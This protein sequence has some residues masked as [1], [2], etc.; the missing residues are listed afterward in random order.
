MKE[1]LI[2]F[3]SATI[4]LILG[5]L[6]RH[7]LTKREKKHDDLQMVNEAV[8]PLLESVKMLTAQTADLIA[9]L[10]AE[11]TAHLE[12]IRKTEALL[13]EREVL[14]KKI[15]KMNKEIETL[16]KRIEELTSTI[17]QESSIDN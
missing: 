5:F 16:K 3:A 4:T 13:A 14:T 17:K 11:Q 2:G 9:K 12:S 8:N 1:L 6:G 15:D 10:T 7:L